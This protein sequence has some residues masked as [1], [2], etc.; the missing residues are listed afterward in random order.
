MFMVE[1]EERSYKTLWILEY[2]D[3]ICPNLKTF[4]AHSEEEV[5]EQI[6]QWAA[7]VSHPVRRINLR[8]YP[9]GFV[10][11]RLGEPKHD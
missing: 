6:R 8:H 1:E 9:H 10:L 2:F 4:H 3:D 7:Q 5:E 11:R